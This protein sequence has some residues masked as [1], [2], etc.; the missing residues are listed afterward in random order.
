MS[1][2]DRFLTAI[3]TASIA[4]CGVFADDVRVD[5]VVPEW[6]FPIA[7]AAAVEEQ[8]ARWF[9]D[10]GHFEELVRTPLPTGELVE[11]TLAWLEGGVPTAA[12]QVHV[13]EVD[14]DRIVSDRV[15]CGGRW[16]ASLLARMEEAGVH[17]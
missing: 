1:A 5:A 16:P 17:A 10:P 14:G 11:F 6:R 8:F 7:G 3:E 12:R 2:I 13:L 15:W 4:G 9:A